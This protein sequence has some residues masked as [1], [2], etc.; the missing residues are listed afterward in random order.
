MKSKL[1]H[2]TIR[3]LTTITDDAEE[4]KRLKY[5][6]EI[7]DWDTLLLEVDKSF[8]VSKYYHTCYSRPP[9]YYLKMLLANEM[10]GTHGVES[11]L[12]DEDYAGPT[13]DYC[14]T[15][16]AYE[17]TLLYVKGKFVVGDWGSIVENA[18]RRSRG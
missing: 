5:I 4:A 14:N 12:P 15:G 10:L 3:E 7:L 8:H 18:E 6:L 11:I 2:A 16:D 1:H 13:I 9:M 17:T